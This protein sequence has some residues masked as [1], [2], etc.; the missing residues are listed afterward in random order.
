MH[1]VNWDPMCRFP[2][3]GIVVFC[4]VLPATFGSSRL[5]WNPNPN[6]TKRKQKGKPRFFQTQLALLSSAAQTTAKQRPPRNEGLVEFDDVGM[7]HWLHN[8]LGIGHHGPMVFGR[9]PL[10]NGR[11]HMIIRHPSM[12]IELKKSQ[13]SKVRKVLNAEA[14]MHWSF[15]SFF[16]GRVATRDIYIDPL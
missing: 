3:A 9:G 13:I 14:H 7:V 2:K 12:E 11:C 4:I 15:M 6:N 16:W 5:I 10:L 1:A 8:G